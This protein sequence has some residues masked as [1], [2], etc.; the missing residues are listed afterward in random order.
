MKAKL[1]IDALVKGQITHYKNTPRESGNMELTV[2]LLDI[3]TG[4]HIYSA[5]V[6]TDAAG[7]LTGKT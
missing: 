4:Q 5:M 6:R 2:W 7:I 3:E 1:N